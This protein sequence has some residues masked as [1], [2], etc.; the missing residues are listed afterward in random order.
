MTEKSECT[1]SEVTMFRS[2]SAYERE[3]KCFQWHAKLV[4]TAWVWKVSSG[5]RV[6]HF[7][8]IGKLSECLP[9]FLPKCSEVHTVEKE[10]IYFNDTT[11]N[12]LF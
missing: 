2:E 4:L 8:S 6:N 1:C 5:K 3:S 7:Q 9:V 11:Q 12:V 10:Q